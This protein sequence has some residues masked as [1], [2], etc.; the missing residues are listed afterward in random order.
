MLICNKSHSI[1]WLERKMKRA[2]N[3]MTAV[4]AGLEGG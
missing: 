3:G 2:A 1:L 4:E